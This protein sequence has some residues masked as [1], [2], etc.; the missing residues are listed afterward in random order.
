LQFVCDF[1]ECH[2][3]KYKGKGWRSERVGQSEAFGQWRRRCRS[4]S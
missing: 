4:C 2:R 1:E 3:R